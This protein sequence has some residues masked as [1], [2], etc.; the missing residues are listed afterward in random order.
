[1]KDNGGL[2]SPKSDSEAQKGAYMA[3]VECDA[4]PN[5]IKSDELSFQFLPI[6]V[7]SVSYKRYTL[8]L[9]NRNLKHLPHCRGGLRVRLNHSLSLRRLTNLYRFVTNSTN[10]SPSPELH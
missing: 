6:N 8:F 2:E 3:S 5:S 7:D 10:S 1:M 9:F 4:K